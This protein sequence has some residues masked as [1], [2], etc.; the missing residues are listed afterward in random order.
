M[1]SRQKLGII[2]ESKGFQNNDKNIPKTKNN[3]RISLNNVLP[4]IMSPFLKKSST[5]GAI[6]NVGPFFRIYDPLSAQVTK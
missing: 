5:L 4:T 1:P 3:Y 6:H 2:L